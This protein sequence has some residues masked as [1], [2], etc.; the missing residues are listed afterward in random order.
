MPEGLIA[1]GV[2][3]LVAAL[4]LL[5][6]KGKTS[7]PKQQVVHK[8]AANEQTADLA[9]PSAPLKTQATAFPVP[10][11]PFP[12]SAANK[13]TARPCKAFYIDNDTATIP[14][15]TSVIPWGTGTIPWDTD[16][17]PWNTDAIPWNTGAIIPYAK[18]RPGSGDLCRALCN[19]RDTDTGTTPCADPGRSTNTCLANPNNTH[20]QFSN[21]NQI[22]TLVPVALNGQLSAKPNHGLPEA[23]TPSSTPSGAVPSSSLNPVPKLLPNPPSIDQQMAELIADTWALQQQAAELGRRLNYLSTCIQHSQAS[24]SHN[25]DAN[26]RGEH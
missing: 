17:I 4:F 23:Q 6:S 26:S 5:R 20:T 25:S 11:V 19:N 10:Q 15:D 9:R 2:L 14:W 24:T 12:V 3:A 16:A 13:Q 21:R 8:P 22:Q 7:Q 18:S 1:I